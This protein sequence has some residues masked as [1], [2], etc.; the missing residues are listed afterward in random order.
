MPESRV[1]QSS[2]S[3]AGSAEGQEGTPRSGERAPKSG[4][5]SALTACDRSQQIP[6]PKILR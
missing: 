1:A 3:D 5:R 2:A 6:R 4:P